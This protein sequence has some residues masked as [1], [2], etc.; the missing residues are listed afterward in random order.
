LPPNV[1]IK[2]QHNEKDIHPPT[3]L[4]ISVRC[5]VP[6][7]SRPHLTTDGVL[8][9]PTAKFCL[10]SNVH[11]AYA[12]SALRSLKNQRRGLRTSRGLRWWFD[13]SMLLFGS[14]NAE[15]SWT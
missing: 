13:K 15:T 9:S 14:A 10:F 11:Q 1:T 3:T 12:L 8:L 5:R 7:N 6:R 4:E 2:H